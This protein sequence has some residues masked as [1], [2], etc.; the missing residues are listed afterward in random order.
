MYQI[1]L[2]HKT[3]LPNQAV[4]AT[5]GNFDGLH[6][7][8]QQLL[9]TFNN[10][11]QQH[12]AW[13]VLITFDVLPHEYFADQQ[14]ALRTSRIGLLRDKI[15]FLQM[16][17]LVDE[18]VILHFGK[19]MANLLPN[20]FIQQ[21]LI[22]KLRI[23][24]LVIGHDFR[25]GA[26]ARGSLIDLSNNGIICYEVGE[27]KSNHQRI[28]SSLIREFA[29]LQDLTAIKHYLGRNIQYTSRVVRGNQLARK[30][31]F[32]TINFNLA[33][34]RP[35]LWGIYTSYVYIEGKRYLGVTNIGINPTVSEG[36]V[37]KIETHLLDIDL[38]LYGKIATVEILHYLRP[39]LK[40]DNLTA[41]FAQM[42][43][44]LADARNFFAQFKE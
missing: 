32:P 36:K 12:N 1:K 8:H 4:I 28:S 37:Y 9:Q 16:S 38:D 44:D 15:R 27:I 10:Y 29:K 23:N 3:K 25:F 19:A 6:L 42:Y 5:I 26:N 2:N 24:Y 40:F 13:R 35:V 20:Q 31:N 33:R 14:Q 30:W 34:I 39:E 22:T 43:Q 21:L 18:V 17:Q 7:G 11:A 41:L